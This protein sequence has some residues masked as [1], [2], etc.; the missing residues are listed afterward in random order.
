[1]RFIAF[2]TSLLFATQAF[3]QAG[4]TGVMTS[5]TPSDP[6]AAVLPS[7]DNAST[8]WKN[9][10][11]A[12][13]GGIPTRNTQCGATVNPIGGTSDDFTNIQNAI[14]ACPAGEVVQLGSG[15]F[16]VHQADLPLVIGSGISLRGGACTGSSSPYCASVITVT[17]GALAYT[18]GN[19]GTSL[20]GSPCPNGGE[21]VI[22]MAPT[23]PDYEF[24][25]NHCGNP[26]APLGTGCGAV[27]L[28]AD[29]AQGD[30][31]I[32]VASTSGLSVGQ[33]ILIDEASG[34]GW[35]P[36]PLDAFTGFTN[37]WAPDWASIANSGHGPYSLAKG[38][39]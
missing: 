18:G 13:V 33:W 5:G 27:S 39:E 28:T 32:H 24:S 29:A 9:A 26:G 38:P 37:I 25:W 35:V 36:D 10:G 2:I 20:P 31:T 16:N 15:T 6:I 19:C 22:L 14:N 30:T 21:P 34:A 23:S 8:N 1:V 12:T 3:A 7:F 4:M 17:D 11:M